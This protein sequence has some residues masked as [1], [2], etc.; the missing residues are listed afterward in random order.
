MH[1][2]LASTESAFTIPSFNGSSYL[3]F[4]GLQ[5]PGLSSGLFLEIQIIFK[6]QSLNGVILYNGQRMDGGG[7]FVSINLVDGFVEFRF[8]PGNGPAVIRSL[9]SIQLNEWHTVYASRTAMMGVLQVDDQPEVGGYSVGAFTQ[10]S[11]PL[12]MF[13]GGVSD[14]KDV[15]RDASLTQSLVGCVQKVTING[16]V[17]NLR[18][19]A[20]FGVNVADCPHPCQSNPCQRGGKCDPTLDSYVC[21][22]PLGLVGENCQRGELSQVKAFLSS[23]I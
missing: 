7:D 8:N 23:S 5:D 15:S 18:D 21:R 2:L 17:L 11:L 3:Q 13:I 10:L 9:S 19:E 6:P 4:P 22:C 1:F 12:N 16:R 20:L 14:M